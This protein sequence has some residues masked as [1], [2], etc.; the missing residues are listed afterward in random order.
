VEG[1]VY[2]LDL[3]KLP[4][5]IPDIKVCLSGLVIKRFCTLFNYIIFSGGFKLM[6]LELGH[7][8]LFPPPPLIF[9]SDL[10]L[11]YPVCNERV[12]KDDEIEQPFIF[13]LMCH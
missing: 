10:T 8:L 1:D 11:G 4:A 7:Q 12:T 3:R 2:N 13:I 5:I 9:G 6:A